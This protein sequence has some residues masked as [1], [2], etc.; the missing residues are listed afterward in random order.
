[1]LHEGQIVDVQ[2]HFKIAL[3]SFKNFFCRYVVKNIIRYCN[4]ETDCNRYWLLFCNCHFP[5][6]GQ[7]VYYISS[8]SEEVNGEH[9]TTRHG[10]FLYIF[11]IVFFFLFLFMLI[12][13]TYAVF[14]PINFCNTQAIGK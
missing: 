11:V 7:L 9:L 3:L 12:L 14:N 6:M 10:G 8:K 4:L 13:L 1:M 2:K 5:L